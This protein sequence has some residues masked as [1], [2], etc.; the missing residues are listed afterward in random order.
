MLKSPV[1]SCMTQQ[2]KAIECGWR[3]AYEV[4][5][6]EYQSTL[7]EQELKK[8]AWKEQYKAAEKKKQDAPAR[9]ESDL[10]QPVLRR[11]MTSDA[12]LESLHKTLSENPAGLFVLRDELAGWLAGLERQ[13]REQERAFYLEC[14]NGQGSF[15]IDR[16]GRGSVHVPHACISLFGGIQPARLRSYLADALKGGPSNDGLMQ[17]FQL[18][19]WP[20]T[21]PD[22]N[23]IDRKPDTDA[24]ERTA[25]VYRRITEMDP[26][27]PR[28]LQFEDEAQRFFV[29]FISDL[30][31]RMRD[32]SL[33]P[34]LR[35]HLAKYRS[36]MPALALLF[37]LADDRVAES[38]PLSQA[39]RAG[40]WCDY[41][42]THALRV[43]SPQAAPE[44]EAA[45]RLGNKLA[46]GWKREEG[47]FTVRDV[48]RN[49]WSGLDTVE[50]AQAALEILERHHWV[51]RGKDD[52][53]QRP[54]R[55]S[56]DFYVNPRIGIR[57]AGK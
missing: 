56:E 16:I 3:D 54:G 17:R 48:Y 40:D 10:T 6:H 20:D 35:A 18:I 29:D 47:T 50:A 11:L 7:E 53:A 4:A 34:C 42:W 8:A 13:G 26:E 25:E 49:G 31:K 33:A 55:P 19:V 57:D 37:T 46:K 30:E 15:T 36:L 12:T 5:E 28:R 39:Q 27:K 2:A 1:L 51:R 23:Y 9:P 43:Y 21:P 41:L 45:I 14:W 24:Q 22:W 32:D 52:D 44:I 38:V